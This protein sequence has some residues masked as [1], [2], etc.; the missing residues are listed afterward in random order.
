MSNGYIDTYF[1]DKGHLLEMGVASL[2]DWMAL[3]KAYAG[4]NINGLSMSF[5]GKLSE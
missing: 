1:I 5:H 3:K 2:L 4:V